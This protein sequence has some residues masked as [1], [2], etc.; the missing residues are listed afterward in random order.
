MMLL[1]LRACVCGALQRFRISWTFGSLG[2]SVEFRFKE[3]FF[4]LV[5]RMQQAG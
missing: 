4:L 1:S 5:L 3:R 2:I